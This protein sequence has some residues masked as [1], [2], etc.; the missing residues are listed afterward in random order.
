MTSDGAYVTCAGG[1]YGV[2]TQEVA[3]HKVQVDRSKALASLDSGNQGGLG[4]VARAHPDNTCTR[5]RL[6]LLR[7]RQS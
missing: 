1:P 2:S 4:N 7:L 3:S 5:F 6:S